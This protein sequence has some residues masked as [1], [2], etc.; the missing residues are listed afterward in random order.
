MTTL[1]TYTALTEPDRQ[2]LTKFI[3]QSVESL[4]GNVFAATAELLVLSDTLR[5]ACISGELPLETTL[6][7]EEDQLTIS[8]DDDI[9]SI[10]T[11]NDIPSSTDIDTLIQQLKHESELADPELLRAR[12]QTINSKLELA[13]QRA[14]MEMAELEELLEKK[15]RELWRTT[16]QAEIDSLTGLYNRSVYDKQLPEAVTRC[17]RQQEPLSLV[18]LDLDNFKNVNDTHGHQYGDEHLKRLA[19]VMRRACRDNVDR[20][21]RIGGDEFAIIM[22]SSLTVSHRV[23][24]TILSS[25]DRLVSIGV[26]ELLP[27]ENVKQLVARTDAALYKAKEQGRGQVIAA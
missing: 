2:Q 15:K 10:V 22:F 25:F 26:T 1:L 9:H 19:H 8:W 27:D 14:S 4:G 13:K 24:E 21:C 20:A 3:L 12:N 7:L 6:S 11:L 5:S 23:A 18:L 16:H 17:Q